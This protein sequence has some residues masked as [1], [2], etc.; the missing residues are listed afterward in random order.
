MDNIPL[1]FNQPSFTRPLPLP[2]EF[3]SLGYVPPE[4]V[5]TDEG[6]GVSPIWVSF[7]CNFLAGEDP[8]VLP[9]SNLTPF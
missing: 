3:F 2:C 6:D 9:R 7:F 8:V 4:L 1:R 5:L